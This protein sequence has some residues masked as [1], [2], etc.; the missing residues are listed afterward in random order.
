MA[1]FNSQRKEEGMNLRNIFRRRI[2]AGCGHE[3][4]IKDKVYA[5][6]KTITTVVPVK[7]GKTDYCHECLGK[8]AIR[9]AWCGEVIFIGEPITL[10]TPRREDFKIPEHAVAHN[11][12]PL[13]LVGCLGWN[14]A[15]TGADR[16]G[17]W[18]P[19]GKVFRV[20]SPAEIAFS[21]G[22]TVVT[23]DLGSMSTG[24]TV[25]ISDLGSMSEALK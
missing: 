16:A 2:K 8:M 9:C 7:D 23:N 3:T 4:K 22:E 20:P 11:K 14:C 24:E 25:V 5:F 12:D 15:A 19:P 10:Y 21:T 18:Y 6:G 13:Q 1:I 17:F